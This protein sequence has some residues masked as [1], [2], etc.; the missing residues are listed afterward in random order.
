MIPRELPRVIKVDIYEEFILWFAMPPMERMKLGIENQQQFIEYYKI[1]KNTPT[2]W[3]ARYDFKQR[4]TEMRNDWAFDKT[5][6]VIQGIYRSAIKGNDR[7]QKLWLQYFMGFSERVEVANTTKVEIGVND[8]RF[9]IESLPEPLK[10]KHYAN[11]RELLDDA[12][13]VRNAGGLEESSSTIRPAEVIP[14]QA[15][16][17]AQNIPSAQSDAVASC[18]TLGLRK[19]LEW[20][21]HPRNNQGTPRWWEE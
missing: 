2:V 20:Q 10:T 7:S 4:V 12:S 14:R 16:N 6:D 11:L 19:D 15:H 5:S 8:I 17:I 3:K 18:H 1:G 9:L 21:I 13:A